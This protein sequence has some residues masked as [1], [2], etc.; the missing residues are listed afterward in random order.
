MDIYILTLSLFIFA[1]SFYISIRMFS[2]INSKSI[3]L[4]CLMSLFFSV[5]TYTGIHFLNSEPYNS[6]IKFSALITMCFSIFLLFKISMLDN[7]HFIQNYHIIKNNT[8]NAL[9]NFIFISSSF[10]FYAIL[11]LENMNLLMFILILLFSVVLIILTVSPFI[12][13][14]IIVLN[15]FYMKSNLVFSILISLFILMMAFN[16]IISLKLKYFHKILKIKTNNINYNFSNKET[17]LF[18]SKFEIKS[19]QDISKNLILHYKNEEASINYFIKFDIESHLNRII[20]GNKKNIFLLNSTLIG[21]EINICFSDLSFYCSDDDLKTK[22]ENLTQINVPEEML[23][24]EDFVKQQF[25]LK[26]ILK[27]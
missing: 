14:I 4:S 24:L 2:E 25:R 27:Y 21:T 18:V 20:N 9:F 3:I 15:I 22:L 13:I 11:F 1:T 19:D 26:Q 16:F 5:S 7:F 12:F 6:T 10:F 23:N 8:F 17:N